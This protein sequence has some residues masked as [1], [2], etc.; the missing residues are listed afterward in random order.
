[1]FHHGRPITYPKCPYSKGI[2]RAVQNHISPRQHDPSI[3]PRDG[4]FSWSSPRSWEVKHEELF[5]PFEG[6][7]ESSNPFH[8]FFWLF[9][10]FSG[11]ILFPSQAYVELMRNLF[12]F[13]FVRIN[14]SYLGLYFFVFSVS[15]EFCF[16]IGFLLVSFCSEFCV[17]FGCSVSE[18]W[19]EIWRDHPLSISRNGNSCFCQYLLRHLTRSYMSWTSKIIMCLISPSFFAFITCWLLSWLFVRRRSRFGFPDYLFNTTLHQLLSF[20]KPSFPYKFIFQSWPSLKPAAPRRSTS[21]MT[22]SMKMSSMWFSLS[23]HADTP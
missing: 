17:G 13:S 1:M 12:S 18:G 14:K 19:L 9:L 10:L 22:P 20:S 11:D 7:S 2:G 8:W 3:T 4:R 21:A 5:L 6:W 23:L 16:F 15:S